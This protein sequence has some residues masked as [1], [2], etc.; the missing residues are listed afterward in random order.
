[1]IKELG[2]AET[3]EFADESR[4]N[5]GGGYHQPLITFEYKGEKGTIHDTSCG[6]FGKW[7]EVIIGEKYFSYDGV[8]G[9]SYPEDRYYTNFTEDDREFISC[10]NSAYPEYS[11][12]TREELERDFA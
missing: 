9:Y 12:Y 7:Y 4:A 5:N 2:Y 3:N 11:I 6:D 8:S 10:F 1:M